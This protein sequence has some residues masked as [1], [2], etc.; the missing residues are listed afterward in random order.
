MLF[1]SYAVGAA[2]V[3][4]LFSIVDYLW[5][6]WD[7]PWRQTIHDKTARTTVVPMR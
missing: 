5:P 7:K 4:G 1:R 2:I 3:G 6:F